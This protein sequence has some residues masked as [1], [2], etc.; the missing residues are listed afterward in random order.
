VKALHFGDTGNPLDRKEGRYSLGPLEC[1]GD[2]MFDNV[3]TF[4]KD[5]SAIELPQIDFGQSGDIYFEFKT[6]SQKTM[7]LIHSQGTNGD[8][9]MVSLIS[10][11][12]IQFEYESGK[13]PQGVTVETSYRLDDDQWHSV[14]VERN[15]KEAMVI[16]DGARKGKSRNPLDP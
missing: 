4:R 15:R 9:I 12:H 10:G 5:D 1:D 11:N 2:T 16:V 7:V 14:L 13:G 8:F 6:T 3:V